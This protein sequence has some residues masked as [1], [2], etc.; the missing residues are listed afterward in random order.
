MDVMDVIQKTILNRLATARDEISRFMSYMP[1]DI[2]QQAQDFIE[3]ENRLNLAEF[4]D[5][6]VI[7]VV[8]VP[9]KTKPSKRISD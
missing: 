8:E 3:E 4:K 6:E 9:W 1:L 7:N 5:N 2:V